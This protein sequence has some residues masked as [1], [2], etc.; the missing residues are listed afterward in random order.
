MRT[1]PGA[2]SILKQAE[3]RLGDRAELRL[4]GAKHW[5]NHGG[6]EAPKALTLLEHNLDQFSADEQERILRTLADA[7]L[8]TGDASVARRLVSELVKRKPRD[9]GLRFSQFTLALGTGDRSAIE[10]S[11][12]GIR[13]TENQ[14]QMVGTKGQPVWH[15]AR[16]RYLIWSAKRPGQGPISTD[17]LDEARLNLAAASKSRPAWP[18]LALAEAEID[19]LSGHQDGAI[20]AYRRAIEL[21]AHDLDVIRRTVQL[22]YDRRRYDQADELIRRLQENGLPSTDP[23]FQRL[24]AEVSLQANDRV[25]ALELARKSI[26][27]DSNHYRDRLW[28]GQILW[29]AGEPGQAEPQLRRAV[30]LGGQAPETWITLVQFLARTERKD[31]ARKVIHEAERHLTGEQAPLALARCRAELGEFSQARALL[32]PVLTAHPNDVPTLRADASF[33]LAS[34]APGDAEA[35]LRAIVG[36][37]SAAPEDAEWARRLLANVLASSGNRQ[38][39]LESLQL[40]GLADE[41][42]AYVPGDDEPIE[43]VRAKAK[44]LSL[45]NNRVARRLGDPCR[46]AR[47]RSRARQPRRPI[48]PD[49]A[50]RGRWELVEGESAITA[51]SRQ[52]RPESSLPGPQHFDLATSRIK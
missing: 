35:G 20:N 18:V 34:G 45:R 1:S 25:R 28:L 5:A 6:P 9:L 26:P 36:K 19:E 38:K 48:S 17:K 23:Q 15:F 51:T 37:K 4:A 2:G 43:E 52:R 11:L 42:A 33:A 29:A 8:H 3:D 31:E 39:W 14:L 7:H 22:L 21:G 10:E 27:P 32:R 47:Y 13:V 50:L 41:G 40:L 24:A 49:R 44:V 12:E 30:E 46:P 16:S